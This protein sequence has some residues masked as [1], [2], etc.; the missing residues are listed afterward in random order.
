MFYLNIY[1]TKEIWE[2]NLFDFTYLNIVN[3]K[4]PWTYILLT[5]ILSFKTA[6][7]I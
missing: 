4:Q 1:F 3:E 6:I 5:Q 7:E 2:A